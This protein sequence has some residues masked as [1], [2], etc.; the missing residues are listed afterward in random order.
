VFGQ[1]LPAEG[2]YFSKR[3]G[4]KTKLLNHVGKNANPTKEVE[5]GFSH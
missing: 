3:F 5:V 2:V 4:F 1:Y